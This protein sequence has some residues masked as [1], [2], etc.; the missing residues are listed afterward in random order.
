[1]LIPRVPNSQG[2]VIEDNCVSIALL[3]AATVTNGH[4]LSGCKQQKL[5]L[6]GQEDP[7]VLSVCVCRLLLC[8]E[9]L[10]A[11]Q[12]LF[13]CVYTYAHIC[14]YMYMYM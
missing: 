11:I 2:S 5:V 7:A 6:P 1:M 9:I 10:R 3:V 8:P 14:I 13:V 4:K 12:V